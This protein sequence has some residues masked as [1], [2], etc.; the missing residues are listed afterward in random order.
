MDKNQIIGIV[1][2]F[3]LLFG[4]SIYTAPTAEERAETKR[5][6]DSAR[7]VY[8]EKLKND[9]IAKFKEDSLKKNAKDTLT[10]AGDTTVSDSVINS[11]LQDKFGIFAG[12][13]AGEEKF[14]TLENSKIKVKIS[15]KG[16]YPKFAQVKNF[17]THN[18]D[19]LILFDKEENKF[20][21]NFYH[22][23]KNI[24]TKNLY[25]TPQEEDSVYVVTSG[26]KSVKLRLKAGDNKYIEYVY[27]LKPDDYLLKFD[28]NVVG[29]EKDIAEG[30]EF[31]NMQ[32]NA[33]LRRQELGAYHENMYSTIYYKNFQDDVTYLSEM[34]KSKKED[35]TTNIKWIAYKD[36]FF[37]TILI[38]DKSFSTATMSY[39]KDPL[40]DIYLKEFTSQMSI[41]VEKKPYETIGFNYYIGP[42]DYDILKGIEVN[43]DEELNMQQMI[44]LGWGIFRWVNQYAII[45]LFN[46]LGMFVSNIGLLILLMTIIIKAVLFPLTYKSFK[47]SAKMRVLKPQIDEINEKIP[48]S[49]SMKRQQATMALYKKV[50]VNPLGGCLPMLLQMPILIAMYRFFPGSIELRQKSFLWAT[51]LSTYDSIWNFPGGFSIWG[52]GDHISLFTL[53]MAAAMFV[54]QMLNKSQ[55]SGANNQMPGMKM[56]LYLMPVMMV[57]WFNSYSSG[58]S[59][60]YLLSNLITIAQTLII[61][62]MIDEKALLAKINANKKRVVKK[63]KWQKR[64]EDMQKQQVA[65]KKGKKRK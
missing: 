24:E 11:K 26:K 47:S 45:P 55:M 7:K 25:F 1:L 64:L 18:G 19:S 6:E 32:W 36:L 22:N 44:P 15:T 23:K 57:V 54:S 37:S 35:I 52:Y 65:Q 14:I 50:G 21:L 27:S 30:T 12:N 46:F 10:V 62:K 51:D 17:K 56:M 59:Y 33:K 20:S 2:I 5:K 16:G 28:I 4:Y 42:N 38:A 53:L 49:E 13:Y 3:L 40:Q 58:L 9:S 63:S 29:L 48:K 39:K 34:S 61:R 43:K 8:L 41:P 60:Y 31:I